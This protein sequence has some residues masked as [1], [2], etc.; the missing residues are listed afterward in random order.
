MTCAVVDLTNQ[1]V[2]RDFQKKQK[3]SSDGILLYV[4]WTIQKGAQPKNFQTTGVTTM[5]DQFDDSASH[6]LLF[7]LS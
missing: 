1:N 2:E 7:T 3:A 6:R 5:Q 4:K